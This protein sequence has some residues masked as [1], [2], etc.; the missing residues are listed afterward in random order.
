M[1]HK[2]YKVLE[3]VDVLRWYL[4]GDS[5]RSTAG[6]KNMDRNPVRKYLRL[7][8]E[9]GFA[10][11]FAGDLDEMAYRIFV[12]VQPEDRESGTKKRDGMFLPQAF[13]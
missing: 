1:G 2:E 11:G 7:A 10:V 9:Y 12:A 13:T 8:E 4:A 3:I 5:I 6:S